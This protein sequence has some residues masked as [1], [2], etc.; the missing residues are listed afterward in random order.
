MPISKDLFLSILS[1]DAYNR[2]YSET[3]RLTGNAIGSATTALQSNINE[4]STDRNA[5]FYAISYETQ[6]G[7]V[8]SYRGTNTTPLADLTNDVSEGWG[9]ATG[10]IT[11]EQA[12]LSTGFL[13][14][15][16]GGND[17]RFLRPSGQARG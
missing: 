9:L 12:L 16:Q 7:T 4:G 2:G 14:A 15:V 3:I 11:A 1:M 5:G 13:D 10:D 8:I 17:S 6:Y